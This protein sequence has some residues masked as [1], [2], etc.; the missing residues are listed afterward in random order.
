VGV[1]LV[2]LVLLLTTAINRN[3]GGPPTFEQ[4]VR[5]HAMR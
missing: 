4:R 2:G 3:R 1:V 5:E